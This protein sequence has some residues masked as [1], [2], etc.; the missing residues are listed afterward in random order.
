MILS[1]KQITMALIR[2]RGSAGWSARLLFAN[3][4]DR[5]FRVKAQISDNLQNYWHLAS[6]KFDLLWSVQKISPELAY[7]FS[8]NERFQST[9]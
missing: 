5:F 6:A 9:K 7:I 4:K 8:E 1:N 2:L 3:P